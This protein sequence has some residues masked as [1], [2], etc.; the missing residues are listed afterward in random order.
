VALANLRYL[1][2]HRNT[3]LRNATELGQY[4]F[5]RLSRMHFKGAATVRGKGLALG[6]SV[7]DEGYASEIGERCRKNGL[8]I[9]AEEDVLMLFP[10]L[11]ISRRTAARGLDIFEKCL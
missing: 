9:S 6:I 8:L 2:R 3:L 1:A 5:D 10:A 4:F 11:T 7:E